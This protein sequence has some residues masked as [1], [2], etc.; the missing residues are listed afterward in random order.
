M[1]GSKKWYMSRTLW[2]NVVAF[3]VAVLAAFGYEGA[4]PDGWVPFVVPVVTIINTLLRLVTN[5]KLTA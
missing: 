5:K 3:V 1:N 4:L 2:F